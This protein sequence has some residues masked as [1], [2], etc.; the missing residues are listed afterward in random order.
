MGNRRGVSLHNF[1]H[2]HHMESSYN[3]KTYSEQQILKISAQLDKSFS[4]YL[5]SK[6]KMTRFEKTSFKL[7]VTG[8]VTIKLQYLN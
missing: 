7:T 6:A 2:I 8:I 5:F 3:T 4:K 1:K